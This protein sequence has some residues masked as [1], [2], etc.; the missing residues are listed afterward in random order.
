MFLVIT[1]VTHITPF[2]IRFDF[3]LTLLV[4]ISG[5]SML[6]FDRNKEQCD[7]QG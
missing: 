2:F 7:T 5:H 6:Q 1:F 3:G 4:Q